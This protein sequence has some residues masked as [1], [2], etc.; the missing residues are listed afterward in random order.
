MENGGNCPASLNVQVVR[1]PM[2]VAIGSKTK[3]TRG[4][5]R[6]VEM[7]GGNVGS[8]NSEAPDSLALTKLF[9][10]ESDGTGGRLQK[11]KGRSLGVC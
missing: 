2:N 1:D 10:Q 6:R 11:S 7:Q 3:K 4:L 9:F 5:K 8:K